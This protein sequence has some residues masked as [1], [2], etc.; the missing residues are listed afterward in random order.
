MKRAGRYTMSATP[1]AGSDFHP[2]AS[3]D[4][5]R[6]R[7]KLL[8]RVRE[9]FEERGFL[10]VETPLLSADTVVDRHLD[11]FQ[12]GIP[13][14]PGKPPRRLWLQTWRNQRRTRSNFILFVPRSS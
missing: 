6:L 2:T 12:T 7:A 13:A 3:S 14:E 5:L 8:R 11:P 4:N 10:E 9:F 1:A